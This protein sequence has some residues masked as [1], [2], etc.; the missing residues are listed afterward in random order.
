M[1]KTA[2]HSGA[3]HALVSKHIIRPRKK[4][5]INE[6]GCLP[7]D[8][9]MA[10]QDVSTTGQRS[11]R[12]GGGGDMVNAAAFCMLLDHFVP[13]GGNG[14]LCTGANNNRV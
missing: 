12:W 9:A 2:T 14:L 6:A 5:L 11:W 8:D 13:E 3:W 1:N 7:I 4:N 10:M